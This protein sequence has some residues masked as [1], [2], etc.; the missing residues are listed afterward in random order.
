M[1]PR[2]LRLAVLGAGLATAACAAG[3]SCGSCSA[4][5]LVTQQSEEHLRAALTK[6]AKRA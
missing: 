4:A 3:A 1:L 5:Q 6:F 2:A